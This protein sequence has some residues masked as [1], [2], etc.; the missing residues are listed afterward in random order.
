MLRTVRAVVACIVV[1]FVCAPASPADTLTV[2]GTSAAAPSTSTSTTRAMR[3]S[4]A[5]WAAQLG[6]EGL[7]T[8]GGTRLMHACYLHETWVPS[9][10]PA[11]EAHRYDNITN[12]PTCLES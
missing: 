9:N 8:H 3:R 6:A 1:Q 2:S 5:S 7:H 12:T 4:K 10:T 11:F